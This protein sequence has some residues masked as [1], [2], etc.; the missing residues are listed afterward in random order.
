[1]GL[2][3]IMNTSV[4]KSTSWS[5]A[6]IIIDCCNYITF[7]FETES[8]SSCFRYMK[9]AFFVFWLMPEFHRVLKSTPGKSMSANTLSSCAPIFCA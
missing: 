3:T 9:I 4:A 7:Y 8:R 1:M 5:L 2:D 6:G